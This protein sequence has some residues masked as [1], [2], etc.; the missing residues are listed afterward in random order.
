M[1]ASWPRVTSWPSG[2]RWAVADRAFEMTLGP[3]E[4][5]RL[6]PAAVGGDSYTGEGSAVLE[7]C[8]EGRSWRI[9]LAPLPP[10]HLGPIAMERLR[11]ELAFRGY[12]PEA[13]E[14]FLDRFMRHYQRGGG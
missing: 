12:S 7:H 13:E 2:R 6:L 8:A 3:A 14:A 1:D 5:L 4:F 10:I 11:V 9:R